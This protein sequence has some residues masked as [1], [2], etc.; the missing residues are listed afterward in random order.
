MEQF[1][2]ER[3]ERRKKNKQNA[4][5]AFLFQAPPMEE[6]NT[7]QNLVEHKKNKITKKQ[8]YVLLVNSTV[9]SNRRMVGNCS[10]SKPR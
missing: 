7:I 9:E 4:L 6:S 1:C 2:K 10:F 3:E 5:M 8:K